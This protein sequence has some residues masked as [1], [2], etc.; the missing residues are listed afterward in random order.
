M[1]L[2]KMFAKSWGQNHAENAATPKTGGAAMLRDLETIGDILTAVGAEACD[3]ERDVPDLDEWLKRQYA[4]GAKLTR[5]ISD[6]AD[7][8][9]RHW[10]GVRLAW[11]PHGVPAGRTVAIV[12]S[13]LGR[14]LDE[15]SGWFAALRT[16][17]LRLDSQADLLVTAAGTTTARFVERCAALFGL[18]V[19]RVHIADKPD[20]TLKRWFVSLRNLVD[21]NRDRLVDEVFLSP[22]IPDSGAAVTS[23]G[24][25]ETPLRDRAVVAL[26]QSVLALGVR[27]GGNIESTLRARLSDP[28]WPPGRVFVAAGDQ[29]VPKA[30]VDDLLERGAVGWL[31]LPSTNTAS[32]SSA[33]GGAELPPG[34]AAE[35]QRRWS[36]PV[37]EFPHDEPWPFLTHC[38][39]RCD[40]PW[41]DQSEQ[42]YLDDLILDRAGADHSALAALCR[43]LR[44]QRLVAT[45]TTI[46]GQSRVVSFTAAPWQQL[47]ERHVF[48]GHRGRWDFEPY[49]VCI[50]RDWLQRQ[51]ARPVVYGDDDLWESLT[52]SDQP[53]FQRRGTQ[54]SDTDW[55]GEQEWRHVGNVD[56]SQLPADA[57]FVIA[58]SPESARLLASFS[59]W[60]VTV[61]P[62]DDAY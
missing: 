40:G 17:C 44:Q 10:I 6:V 47:R 3:L 56:L 5:G 26:A 1:I 15:H 55:T 19:L 42:E 35:S 27:R 61:V 48:R 38:T 54:S 28:S 9:L 41:P 12:S 13:R 16:A 31:L 22:P 2:Q 60:P 62:P 52:P 18:R 25:F 39:R 43:I 4:V 51:G 24:L 57:G 50:R 30:V 37:I 8:P 34:L 58:P 20:E 21:E 36:A 59:R 29:L 33:T 46:R 11:W 32:A 23:E 49:G 14:K 53:F 45:A 7:S